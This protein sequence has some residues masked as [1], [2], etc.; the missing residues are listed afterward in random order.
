MTRAA[1]FWPAAVVG[2]LALNVIGTLVF[3]WAAS[4]EEANTVEPDYYR[5][6]VAW[7]STAAARQ[8]AVDLG[9]SLEASIGPLAADGQADVVVR[10]LDRDGAPVEGVTLS[11]VAIHNAHARHPLTA[12]LPAVAPGRFERRLPVRWAGRWELRLEV[13]RDG[14]VVPMS[15]HAE[16]V[17]G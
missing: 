11:L 2:M 4:D 13:R 6:A 9:W 3:M 14:V 12:A 8:R 1:W 17:A 16:A 15:V 10:L 5:K 7:D